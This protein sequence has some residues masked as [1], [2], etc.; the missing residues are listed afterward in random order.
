MTKLHHK[1]GARAVPE[2]L[3]D[4][5]LKWIEKLILNEWHISAYVDGGSGEDG[6]P[7]AEVFI[8]RA[9][10]RAIIKYRGDLP[11][12]RPEDATEWELTTV[13]ELLHVRF[14]NM[15]NCA[16]DDIMIRLGGEAYAVAYSAFDNQIEQ[17]IEIMA[18][19]LHN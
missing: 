9:T 18:N 3:R 13:H 11:E 19:V 6:Q 1:S 5:L 14:S 7:I 8:T 15:A 16:I 17:L 12:E 10:Q 4:D 2:W